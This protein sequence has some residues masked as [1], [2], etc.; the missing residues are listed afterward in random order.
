MPIKPTIDV[1]QANLEMDY[2]ENFIVLGEKSP[3]S[4]MDSVRMQEN[5][6]MAKAYTTS[7]AKQGVS[8]SKTNNQR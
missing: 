4:M 5:I 1:A 3:G 6:P 2:S 8:A 7:K